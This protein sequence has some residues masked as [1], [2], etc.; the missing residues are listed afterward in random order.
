MNTQKIVTSVLLLFFVIGAVAVLYVSNHKN[1]LDSEVLIVP[2]EYS[3]IQNAI[4][5]AKQGATIEIGPGEYEENLRITKSILISGSGI[6][7]TIIRGTAI[8][9][10]SNTSF[11]TYVAVEVS[12]E[13]DRSISVE[14]KN[15]EIHAF[16]ETSLDTSDQFVSIYHNGTTNLDIENVFISGGDGIR[17]RGVG[18]GSVITVSGSRIESD[19]ANITIAGNSNCFGSDSFPLQLSFL[20]SELIPSNNDATSISGRD[21]CGTHTSIIQSTI[22]GG[23]FLTVGGDLTIVNSRLRSH[24][25]I[26][27]EGSHVAVN[28]STISLSSSN[29]I[30]IDPYNWGVS[31]LELNNSQI[32][33]NRGYGLLIYGNECNSSISFSALDESQLEDVSIRG[34]GNLI[35]GNDF[36]DICP[37]DY[38]LPEGFL[39][40]EN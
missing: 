12:T 10:F 2:G 32:L 36:G 40:E 37:A 31:S 3:T 38:P 26:Y 9:R 4:D 27:N 24:A 17:I 16:E 30:G 21:A 33:N 29:G 34:Q 6:G 25:T 14:L 22:E 7:S 1:S 13:E 35:E 23:I 18:S 20:R 11:D 19:K 5:E 8:P 15:L 39:A 28:N